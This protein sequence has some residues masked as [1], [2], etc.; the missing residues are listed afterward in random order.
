MLT[1]TRAS[2]LLEYDAA[3][4]IIRWRINRGGG[5]SAGDVAG[6]L[7]PNGYIYIRVD[8][9]AYMGHH[10]AWLLYHGGWPCV[11]LDHWDCIGSHNRISNLRPANDLDNSR[12]RRLRRDNVAGAKG[13]QRRANG[14]WR[15]RITIDG[16]LV[17]L[18]QFTAKHVAHAA[19]VAAAEKHFGDFARAA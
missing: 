2:S 19:Y 15:A 8:G 17:S 6:G 12:N 13:V 14:M 18:G 7:H 1:Y 16:V 11:D 4:G 9:R 10:I 3:T 5:A